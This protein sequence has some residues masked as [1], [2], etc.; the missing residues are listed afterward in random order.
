MTILG[1]PFAQTPSTPYAIVDN[2][3]IYECDMRAMRRMAIDSGAHH[4][5]ELMLWL[6]C[7]LVWR[8]CA[9]Y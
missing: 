9:W 5:T 1:W 6:L 4:V 8:G 2:N 3:V 7:V